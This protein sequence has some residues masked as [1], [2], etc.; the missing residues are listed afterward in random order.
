MKHLTWQCQINY[1]LKLWPSGWVCIFIRF[2]EMY[3]CISV[4]A[5][6]ALQ[7]M[8]AVRMRV[9]TTDKNITIIHTTPVHQLTSWEDKSCVFCRKQIHLMFQ[10]HTCLE[11]FCLVNGAWSA[12]ISL[13]IQ[14]RTLFRLNGFLNGWI[15][16]AVWILIL[17][18]PIHY[19]LYQCLQKNLFWHKC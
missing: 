19:S 17:T 6:D 11:L 14:T 5:M 12:Q 2:G 16:S 4:S 9:H 13:L 18:A 10:P 7:W 3:H 8:G 1:F 15:L